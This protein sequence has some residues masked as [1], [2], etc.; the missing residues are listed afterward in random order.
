MEACIHRG[1]NQI[2]GSCVE[3]RSG[4]S[5]IVIDLGL[6]LDAEDADV[7][8]L[9]PIDPD[10]LDGV[11]I[12]HP[13]LDHFG[14]LHHIPGHVPVAMGAAARRIIQAA[15]DFMYGPRP[16]LAGPDLSHKKTMEIGPFRITSF[17]VD[18]SA[19]D[20]YA[21]LVEAD[22][23]CV[24]YSG[25]LRDHGRKA[26]LT[27]Q[28]IANPP[29]GVDT[30]LL[31]GSSL[32][33]L[34]E[35]DRFPTEEKISEQAAQLISETAGLVMVHMSAQN[36]DRLVS[37]FKAARRCGRNLVIDLYAAAILEATGNPN[38]P[39]SFWDGVNLCIPQKQRVQIKLGERFALLG[40]H[41]RH[42][43]Y[44]EDLRDNPGNYVLLFRP[45]WMGDLGRAGALDGARFIY[46][47]WRGYWDRGDFAKTANWL[48]EK[49][50]EVD[51]LHTS[52]HGTPGMLRELAAALDPRQLV[53]IHTFERDKYPDLFDNV[54]IHDDGT[55]W[56][57]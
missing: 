32:G 28:L 24:F 48:A 5:R 31:E 22:G 50:I 27:G 46:S 19:Y 7:S 49:G 13:H 54:V 44:P 6:P 17:L 10:S 57:V 11:V 4:S 9:P 51:F 53:P 23:R 20:A 56:E 52:G 18:H 43:I 2:G 16:T 30:L 40:R 1:A 29:G 38:I 15:G 21:L 55:W 25:D 45:L 42:R 26:P 37:V 12:S 41:S 36:I 39:Q 33:R 3:L 8:P 35:D 14:L 34:G 47:Q